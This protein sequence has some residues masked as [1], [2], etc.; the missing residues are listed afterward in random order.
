MRTAVAYFWLA[1]RTREFSEVAIADIS[2]ALS[3]NPHAADL[4]MA[5]ATYKLAAKDD[6]GVEEAMDHVKKL[7]PNMTYER[8]SSRGGN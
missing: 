2:E 5:L 6:A 3:T 1:G 7:V 4:W 8:R